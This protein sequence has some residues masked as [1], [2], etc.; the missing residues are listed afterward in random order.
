MILGTY[1]T[2]LNAISIIDLSIL[3]PMGFG[4]ILGGLLFLKLTQYF[5]QKYFSQTYYTI[6]GFV[7]GSLLVLYPGFEFSFTGMISLIIFVLCFYVGKMF[8]SN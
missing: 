4:L 8:E 5:M 3:I 2:Y 1:E 6:I 7:V